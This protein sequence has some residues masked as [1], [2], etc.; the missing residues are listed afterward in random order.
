MNYITFTKSFPVSVLCLGKM[1]VMY[2]ER[3]W[4][5]E[6]NIAMFSFCFNFR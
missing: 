4:L 1:I 2:K 3:V 6:N 5:M